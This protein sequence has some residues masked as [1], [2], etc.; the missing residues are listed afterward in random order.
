ME[1]ATELIARFVLNGY[2][3]VE[4]PTVLK[5]NPENRKPHLRPFSDGMRI[6]KF[7]IKT[8]IINKKV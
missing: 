1:F 5:Q 4:I 6:L 3:I 7:M 8:L 2:K